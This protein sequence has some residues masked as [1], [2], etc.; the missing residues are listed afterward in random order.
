MND[1]PGVT[2]QRRRGPAEIEQIVAE[3]AQSGLRRTEFCRR[4]GMTLG[5]LHRYLRRMRG[6]SGSGTAKGG[7]VPVEVADGTRHESGAS[8]ALVLLRGR[9][10][11]VGAGFDPTTLQRLV[12]LLEKM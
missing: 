2:V 10:I 6:E 4:H 12:S 1:E 9:R 7:L 5:T 8:L 3:F 11:E